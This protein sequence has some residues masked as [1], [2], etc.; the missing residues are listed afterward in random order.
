MSQ[1]EL[2]K[3]SQVPQ[4]VISDVESGRQKTITLD[5][6]TKLAEALGVSLDLLAGRSHPIPE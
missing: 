3:R 2:H 4:A 1:N 5:T 6:A